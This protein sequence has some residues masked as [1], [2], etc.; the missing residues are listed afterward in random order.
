M[1][2]GRARSAVFLDRDG[3]LIEDVG[4]LRDPATVAALDG[5]ACALRDLSRLGFALVVVS[6]QSGI[7]RGIISAA[8][9]AAVHQRFV[10]L[11][12]A[13][14]VR[15]DAVS[16]CPHGPDEGCACRK[17]APGM[18]LD[19]AADLDIDLPTSF[20]VGDKAS[21]VEAGRRAGCRSIR[22]ATAGAP[23]LAAG[24]SDGVASDWSAVCRLIRHAT[25]A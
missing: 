9:A 19:A 24:G 2:A 7:A 22:L 20:M 4:Y 16:Y 11:Y 8:E 15:Y 12:A 3:T 25:P 17:P 13:D 18:L 14:G 5:A 6:N 23:V 1:T 21:D 10:V